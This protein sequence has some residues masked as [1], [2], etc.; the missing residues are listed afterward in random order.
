MFNCN[1]LC[2]KSKLLWLITPAMFFLCPFMTC[3]WTNHAKSGHSKQKTLCIHNSTIWPV[4]YITSSVGSLTRIRSRGDPLDLFMTITGTLGRLRKVRHHKLKDFTNSQQ[5]EF[6]AWCHPVDSFTPGLLN[7]LPPEFRHVSLE[8]R[9]TF[10]CQGSL[11]QTPTGWSSEKLAWGLKRAMTDSIMSG[12]L[13]Y[14]V[15]F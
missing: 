10:S 14:I 3:C 1:T 7:L 5:M 4:S 2:T 12:L 13:L 6:G 9:V 11:Q 15:S 8:S